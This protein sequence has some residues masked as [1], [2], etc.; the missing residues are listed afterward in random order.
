MGRLKNRLPAY[1]FENTRTGKRF[2]WFFP[3]RYSA[4]RWKRN[5]YW[6]Y[7]D[8][9]TLELYLKSLGKQE[10]VERAIEIWEKHREGYHAMKLRRAYIV[11]GEEVDGEQIDGGVE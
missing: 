8:Y 1:Y 10:K 11:L 4:L 2:T 3:S 9:G 5:H 6:R 7:A